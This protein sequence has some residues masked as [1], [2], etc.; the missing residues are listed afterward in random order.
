[1]QALRGK[2]VPAAPL[3]DTAH[4]A[5]LLGHR[6]LRRHQ[7]RR[8]SQARG[9]QVWQGSGSGQERSVEDAR[10]RHLAGPAVSILRA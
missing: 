4:G 8:V 3:R 5:A 9:G 6:V 2:L 1:M 10:R 7:R